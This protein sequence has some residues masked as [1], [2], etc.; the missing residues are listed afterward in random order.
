[1]TLFDF[2]GAALRHLPAESAHKMGICALHA[3]IG[4]IQKTPDDPLLHTRIATLDLP[5]PVG[6]AAGFDKNAQAASAMI[7]AGFGWAECGTVTPLAQAG[8]ARPRLFRLR[9]DQA[10]I[11]RMGFNNAGLERFAR[12]IRQQKQ[13]PGLI[14]A[15]IGANKTADD[16][17]QDYVTGL[18]RL[19][20]LPDWFTINISSP[21]TPGLRAL[22][23]KDA[24]QDLLGRIQEARVRLAKGKASAPVFLKLSPDLEERQIG[25]ICDTACHYGLDGLIISNTTLDRPD[26]LKSI[27]RTQ[28]GGLSGQPLF[29]RST[30]ILRLFHH[31]AQGRLTLIGVGGIASG[32]QAY[33]KIRAGASAVQLYTA[34]AYQ[35]PSLIQTIKHELADCLRA[36]GFASIADAV[37][38]H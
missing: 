9:R 27:S 30:E 34:L 26:D 7:R 36:D 15:N 33:A 3:G 16:R 1:M 21:N 32:Q 24:L 37:G 4:P 25:Q 31:A 2:A 35:G 22:Q 6:L 28:S 29:A 18:E 19:W 14:G 10:V 5:N 23:D 38:Q 12:N 11:N 17:I 13:R 20:G 8:N